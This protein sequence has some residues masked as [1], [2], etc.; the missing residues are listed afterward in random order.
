[1]QFIPTVEDEIRRLAKNY[2]STWT[3]TY[4]SFKEWMN[5]YIHTQTYTH[6]CPPTHKRREMVMKTDIVYTFVRFTSTNFFAWRR[7][8]LYLTIMYLFISYCKEYLQ[9][10]LFSHTQLHTRLCKFVFTLCNILDIIFTDAS[11]FVCSTCFDSTS[12]DLKLQIQS[13]ILIYS[14]NYFRRHKTRSHR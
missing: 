10:K 12:H 8:S 11:H 1:M 9:L 13:N 7:H 3:T 14:I 6:I 4:C 5:A 2:F